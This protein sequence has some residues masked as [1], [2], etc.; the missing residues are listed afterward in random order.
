MED[1]TKMTP[2]VDKA[3]VVLRK[4]S[5]IVRFKDAFVMQDFRQ[6]SDSVVSNILVPAA[7]SAFINVVNGLLTGILYNNNAPRGIGPYTSPV[8]NLWSA[9]WN[10][11]TYAGQGINYQGIS[12]PVSN[13]S[14][15]PSTV[16]DYRNIEIMPNPAENE[17][18]DDAQKKATQVLNSLVDRLARCQKVRIADLFDACGLFAASTL[19]NYGWTT[20][21]GAHIQFTG[22]GFK[23]IMPDPVPLV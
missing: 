13:P 23:F 17:T 14:L 4:K 7:K 12:R 1:N 19:N 20:L 8:Q 6:A 18:I 9:A 15:I 11:A 21:Q 5:W 22:T 2:I 10:G 16:M 3:N